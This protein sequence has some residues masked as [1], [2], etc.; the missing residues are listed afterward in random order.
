MKTRSLHSWNLSPKEA[1]EIQ[2]RLA[3][4]VITQNRLESVRFVAGADMALTKNPPRAYA[5]V[6][7]LSFP[8]L[9]VVE[10]CG[11]VSDL[12]FPY[13]P[14]LLAFRE[15]PAL[16]KAFA[17][18]RQEPDL[19]MIDGQGLAHPRACGIA[20]HIGLWLDKPTIGCAKSR[21]FGAYQAPS[22]KRGSWTPLTGNQGEVIGAA[23]RTKDKTNPVFV[24]AG[25]KIDLS[26][27][28]HYVLACS[29][30]YRI[31]E[32]TRR[33]DHFVARLKREN[34]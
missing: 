3:A 18:I 27:A 29:Q 24:S 22:I 31:P 15:A 4:R 25:H 10:E 5:G 21:L 17:R 13:I 32:P 23:V 34:Q 7:V 33:A 8:D 16:L 28:I 11:S 12:T 9:N 1:I 26:S 6:V 2:K 19:V 30:G 20:C 14:G